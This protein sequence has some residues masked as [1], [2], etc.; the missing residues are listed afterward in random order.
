MHNLTSCLTAVKNHLI[1]YCETIYERDG[2]HLFW[3]MKILTKF[4]T[5]L[6]LKA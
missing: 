3:S 5:I 2:I 4:W 1:K 6:Y